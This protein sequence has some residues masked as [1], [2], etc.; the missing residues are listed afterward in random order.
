MLIVDPVRRVTIAEI[1]NLEWF[2]V[3]LPDYLQPVPLELLD[4]PE[5]V[6]KAIVEELVKVRLCLHASVV[7]FANEPDGTENEPPHR[8]RL[9]RFARDGQQSS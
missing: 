6:D 2:N 8:N 5:P 4:H 1:R 3:G 7:S 9:Q